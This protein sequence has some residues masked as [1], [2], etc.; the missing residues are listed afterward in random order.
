MKV[1]QPA[2][3]RCGRE[4]RADDD[5]REAGGL[6]AISTDSASGWKDRTA[7]R[8]SAIRRTTAWR[9]TDHIM[10]TVNTRMA[11]FTKKGKKFDS[12]GK[13]L[14]GAVPNNT[15]FNGFSGMC[16]TTNNGDTVIRYD[17]L[18]DR[19]LIVMP[20]FRRGATRPDQPQ[21]W[22][23]GDT[24]W[25][26]PPGVAGQPGRATKMFVPPP[27]PPPT[28]APTPVPGAATPPAGRAAG[29]GRGPAATGPYSMCYAVSV[30]SDPLGEYYRYEFL[31]PLFPDYPQ[32]AVWPDGCTCRRA[33]ATTSSR[34]HLRGRSRACSGR[35][36]D[37]Q[38]IVIDGVSF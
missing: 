12:T 31:R 13:V 5:G 25:S 34:A 1:R 14:F 9:L 33:P 16:D 30:T 4:G 6:A 23:S 19:W 18:A 28:P 36:R 37:G 20:I 17:Q 22:K 38:C 35:A 32:P 11:V 3:E 26:A 10:Q 29:A 2:E 21:E 8:S 15:V 27:P 24:I 7:C